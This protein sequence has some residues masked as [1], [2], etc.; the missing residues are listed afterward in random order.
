MARWPSA[1]LKAPAPGKGRFADAIW[2]LLL[3][4]ALTAVLG[5]VWRGIEHY[6]H[7]TGFDKTGLVT[8]LKTG[9]VRVIPKSQL[10]RAAWPATIDDIH[11]GCI[12][13]V[14]GARVALAADPRQAAQL[15]DGPPDSR[16]HVLL[17]NRGAPITEAHFWR[18]AVDGWYD[19]G[20]LMLDTLV[21]GLYA[22]A[23]LL[24][25][26]RR[27][28]DPV[29]R[30][31]SLAFLLIV[32]V[33]NGPVL[34][35][36]WAQW[37]VSYMLALVGFLLMT[38]TLPAYPNGAY[39]PRAM[40][41]VRVAVPAATA[42]VFILGAAGMPWIVGWFVKGTLGV[43][44]AG[45]VLL[46]LRYRRMQP[47]LEKQQVKWAV[48]GLSTGLLLLIASA[49]VP[50]PA[51]LAAA[52][53]G[54]FNALT[55]TMEVL[56][57]IGY[58]LIPAGILI[59]LL[60]YRLND[61][62]AAAGKSLGYAVV[63]LI[64]GVVWAVVQSVVGNY[65]KVWFPDPM[66]TTAITAVIAALVFTPARTYVLSWTEKKF[67][68]AL[69]RLRKLPEKLARWQ[70]CDSPD[71]LAKAALAH[72]VEGVGASYAAV[73]GDDGRQW[74]VLAAHGI[75]PEEAAA[76]LAADR[77][78]DRRADPFP[79]RRELADEI[80]QP[81]LLAIGPRSDRA[82][83]T[84]DEKAAIGVVIEPLS[85]ALHA[86]ALRERNIRKVENSLAGID[87]RLARLEQKAVSRRAP[88]GSSVAG[89]SSRT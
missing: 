35:W 41:W 6:R 38:V 65:A 64:V 17:W 39:I 42:G 59:S 4:L 71:E 32:H 34:F 18:E 24:L 58:G 78:A 26:L 60:Q 29:S 21:A 25:R 68:P 11:G 84:N 3:A 53:V 83:Y 22:A 43:V 76:L 5:G 77:P 31:M 87:Q 61:A 62:D 8:S 33:C 13:E 20:V 79:L 73:L 16:V 89:R 27:P 37:S 10:A 67:Q 80:E 46:V 55:A 66:A 57:Q 7:P 81:D 30:R 51:S 56:N 36:E 69:V 40:R 19:L 82:S 74:R 88:K 9:C 48:L 23:A 75:D 85:N 52:N 54:L 15:L 14:D 49:Q 47:G 1:E 28:L 63:T 45:V 70:T 72:L 44:V 12:V 50:K 2:W 86:A